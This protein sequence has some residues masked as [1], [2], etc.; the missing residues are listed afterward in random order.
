MKRLLF[1]LFVFISTLTF[2]QQTVTVT[3]N[4]ED[5]STG[6]DLTVVANLF[7]EAQNIEDFEL[8]L[9]HP[10]SMFCNLDLNGDGN[11]DYIRVIEVGEGTKRLIVLQA[12]LGPDI[13]Q[14]V[15]SI[16]VEKEDSKVT[17][18]I[19]GDEYVY[20]TNY[21]I[22]PTY[23]YY[24]RIYRWLWSPAWHC[25]YS[26]WYWDYYPRWWYIHHCWFYDRYYMHCH[27]FHRHH[28]CSFHRGHHPRPHYHD[29]H[30]PVHH[31]DYADR[32]PNSSFQHRNTGKTNAHELTRNGSGV[33]NRRPNGDRTYNSNHTVIRN[34]RNSTVTRQPS[35]RPTQ[36]Q[37]SQ[38]TSTSQTRTSTTQQRPSSTSTQ[39]TQSS[40]PTQ[41]SGSS[42]QSRPSSGS[43][44][45]QP[46]RNSGSYSGGSRSSSGGV[47][48]SSG[49]ST[50]SSG[51]PSRSSGGSSSSRRR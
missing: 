42:Y 19:I 40:Q 32:H 1:V 45:S 3:A 35:Q 48:R 49:S 37:S 51:S 20:G 15:A 17:V 25:W 8:M 27:H 28:Y 18:Q 29:M 16:Y 5:I 41:R 10:D 7:A 31:H 9:N 23:I 50:R 46:S 43:R 2:S 38:R 30:Q 14:D 34:E 11:V 39:R 6:L 33:S 47:S 13:Y 24:P 12:L 4:S 26:P 44:T 36:S 22:E 21:I